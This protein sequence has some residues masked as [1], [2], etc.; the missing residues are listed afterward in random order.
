MINKSIKLISLTLLYII[1]SNNLFAQNNKNVIAFFSQDSV[2]VEPGKTFSSILRIENHLNDSIKIDNIKPVKKYPNT[3]YTP[4]FKGF[5][6]A[7]EALNFQ[8][9]MIAGTELLIS[10]EK[11]IEYI[12]DYTKKDLTKDTLH[13]KYHII[14]E[15]Q[16][17]IA[18]INTGTDNFYNPQAEKNNISFLIE[19]PGYDI[20]NLKIHLNITP[21]QNLHLQ[22]KFINVIM[23]PRERKVINI[24]LETKGKS[25]YFT[26]YS[27]AVSVYD[28]GKDKLIANSNIPIHTLTSNRQILD[29]NLFNSNKNFIE[30]AYNRLNKYNDI[31][32]L[33][34]NIQQQIL[35]NVSMEFNTV[36][37]FLSQYQNVNIYDTRLVLRSKKIF[38]ELGNIYGSDYDFNMNGKGVKIG[39][40][41]NE[42]NSI[43]ILG[44]SNDYMLYNSFNKT[45]DLGKSFGGKY[46]R[47]T[48]TGRPAQVN[49][50]YSTNPLLNTQTNLS[51]FSTSFKIDSIS[52]LKIEGGASSEV[53]LISNATSRSFNNLGVAGGIFYEMSGKKVLLFSNNYFSS[54]YYAGLRRGILS[55]DETFT[56]RITQQKNFL[57]RYSGLLNTPKYPNSM[58][59]VPNQIGI[60][61]SKFVNH[62]IE[63]GFNNYNYGFSYSILP[64]YTYQKI[65]NSY[66]NA[67]YKAFRM[68]FDISKNFSKHYINFIADGGISFINT[69][70]KPFYAVRFLMNYRLGMLNLNALADINP[71][72]AYDLVNTS[73]KNFRNYSLNTSY[74][75]FT[76]NERLRGTISGG[77]SHVNNYKGFNQFVNNQLEYRISKDWYATGNLFMTRY[78]SQN[79]H[80]AN[81]YQNVQFQIGIKKLFGTSSSPNASKAS[82]RVFEDQNQNGILDKNEKTLENVI[83]NLNEYMAITDNKGFVKFANL[84]RK[85]YIITAKKNGQALHLLSD[86]KITISGNKK[87]ELPVVKVNKISGKMVEIKKKYNVEQTDISGINIYAE[88]LST[89]QITSTVTDWSGAFILNLREGKYR[90]YIQNN[91]YEIVNNSQVI[92]VKNIE[93]T[94]EIIFNYIN[95]EVKIRVKKF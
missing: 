5:L 43:E 55:L 6:K 7:G 23:Q 53:S 86:N 54:P 13:A 36:T 75:Y 71:I 77:I 20:K 88:N 33:K 68:K 12:I 50:L 16:D 42:K 35:P 87:Y 69:D 58:I 83:I 82:F 64:N 65:N 59:F 4:E 37:D 57:F 34:G 1:L 22:N 17:Y 26:D 63:T 45:V 81:S 14:K 44:I 21:S 9:K 28:I 90:I 48:K 38:T 3:L 29:N 66:L 89:N 92:I 11:F 67:H 60:Y 94:K 80:N 46:L 79:L 56:Y 39:Y 30:V 15:N 10:G 19:N 18:I 93:P 2:L 91:R 61:D 47:Y 41:I 95:K 78:N 76:R 25:N 73:T 74:N 8:T 31:Y 40:N 51:S 52:T 49:Y 72:S 70:K 24:P 27:L 32:R 62:L 85:E 84:P